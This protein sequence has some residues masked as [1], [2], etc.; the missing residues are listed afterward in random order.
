MKNR[1]KLLLLLAA[2]S[3]QQTN[4]SDP[5]IDMTQLEPIDTITVDPDVI[6]DGAIASMA[7]M[8]AL[9]PDGSAGDSATIPTEEVVEQPEYVEMQT[10]ATQSGGPFDF[11]GA[12]EDSTAETN[13]E[14][15]SYDDDGD[16]EEPVTMNQFDLLQEI[17]KDSSGSTAESNANEE[18]LLADNSESAQ[19]DN[20]QEEEVNKADEEELLT[21]DSQQQ[22]EEATD[23]EIEAATKAITESASA[24]NENSTVQEAAESASES[25]QTGKDT[26]MTT[27]EAFKQWISDVF[28]N[29]GN[30]GSSWNTFWGM[31]TDVS[32]LLEAEFA[33]LQ[34][35]ETST[36]STE[37]SAVDS[38][39]VTAMQEEAAI[40]TLNSL[41]ANLP[42][43]YTT[44]DL[45]KAIA[46]TTVVSN[47]DFN[48]LLDAA[49]TLSE[50]LSQRAALESAAKTEA[51]FETINSL[52][53]GTL[54]ENYT[55][56][57]LTNMINNG[58]A[59]P[60]DFATLLDAART[61]D[62]ALGE[63]PQAESSATT[64]SSSGFDTSTTDGALEYLKSLGVDIPDDFTA[65]DLSDAMNEDP[66]AGQTAAYNEALLTL[67]S[68]AA[69]R[70]QS[71]G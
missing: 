58:A 31:L 21:D 54:P 22:L 26:G 71:A 7:P 10:S 51:A 17:A 56:A 27:W 5:F 59:D 68:D 15:T 14:E 29:W 16:D 42:E 18:E 67:Y 1:I 3:H 62:F 57:D 30:S 55:R 64:I 70:S 65:A 61:L 52:G 4:S 39:Y 13:S 38:S 8:D 24:I 43:N 20:T 35:E 69:L 50:A 53:A 36:T 63:E 28:T 33:D 49:Q 6:D 12:T 19:E 48:S 25:I 40:E 23:E 47:S 41:G 34:S 9:T 11:N 2:I 37:D 46:D 60:A 45:A 66:P 32:P 44:E